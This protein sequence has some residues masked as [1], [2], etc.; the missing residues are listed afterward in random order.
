MY[1][2]AKVEIPGEKPVT[3]TF[4]TTNL[5]WTDLGSNPGLSGEGAVTN[6]LRHGTAL[7]TKIN[8]HFIYNT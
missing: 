2:Q 3:H 1:W 6:L 4:S 5:T 7:Q 8:V